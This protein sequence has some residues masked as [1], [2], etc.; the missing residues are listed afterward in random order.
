MIIDAHQHFWWVAKRPHT[1]PDAAGDRMH[2]DFTPEDLL[3]EL[4]KA[5]VDGTVLEQSL[6]D[7]DETREYLDLQRQHDFIKAV[8]G[9]IPLIDPVGSARTVE[10]LRAR[11]KFVGMRHLI[12]FEPDP[13][14]LL[15]T[16]VMKSLAHLATEGLVFDAVPMNFRQMETVFKVAASLPDLKIVMNHW[17]R[18][19]IV[20]QG[21][22]PWASM[23]KQA[24]GYP[25]IAVK[26]SPGV[27]IVTRWQWQ[28][29]LAQ[30]Y[31]D[32]LIETMGP[33]RV[34]AA[35]NWPVSVMGASYTELWA[36]LTE[37]VGRLSESERR[38]VLGGTAE[39]VYGLT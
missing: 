27:D 33:N 4:R 32:H 13:D 18:P 29:P 9:W 16:G 21:W 5:G 10:E 37:L 22:E 12:S 39:R 8:V 34:M 6:N 19:P 11:G 15:Q 1:W 28:T 7:L 25:N 36:G 2:R 35:S 3:P 38:A 31:A 23:V 26:M 24:A 17:A 30:R 14:W 20:E